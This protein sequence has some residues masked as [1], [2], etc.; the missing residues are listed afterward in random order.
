MVRFVKHNISD[1]FAPLPLHMIPLLHHP[2]P[3]QVWVM[4]ERYL[5]AAVTPR[6]V[7]KAGLCE[8]EQGWSSLQGGWGGRA[9]RAR[10]GL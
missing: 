6:P 5:P 1:T 10:A 3:A 9:A 4:A 8:P 7:P 2:L